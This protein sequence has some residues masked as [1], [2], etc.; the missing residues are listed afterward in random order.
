MEVNQDQ[1]KGTLAALAELHVGYTMKEAIDE[2]KRCLNCKNPL[3][4]QGCP[5]DHKI[6][7]WIHQLSKRNS[8]HL[9][10]GEQTSVIKT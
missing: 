4:V 5:I 8:S 6:P 3:C 2:A 9:E 10:K 7:E 1:Q